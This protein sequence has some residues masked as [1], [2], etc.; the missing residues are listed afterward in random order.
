MLVIDK[1][2]RFEKQESLINIFLENE[3]LRTK[4]QKLLSKFNKW[5]AY[6]LSNLFI[7]PYIPKPKW[8]WIVNILS[9]LGIAAVGLVFVVNKIFI[10]LLLLFISNVMIH[11]WNKRNIMVYID[12]IP[13]LYLLCKTASKLVDLNITNQNNQLIINSI[14]S[15]NKLKNKLRLFK[16]ERKATSDIEALLLFYWEIIK[17]LF[18][19]EPLAVFDVLKKLDKKRKDIQI[20]FEYIGELDT[21]ISIATLRM[22][23]PYFCK[24]TL[25]NTTESF[26][27][28]DIYHPLIPDCVANSLN[29]THKSIM[30]IGSNMSGKTTFIRTVG[31]NLLLAQTINTC[32]AKDFRLSQTR[33]FSAIRISDDLL[34]DKS[35]YFEEVLTIKN[36]VDESLSPFNNVFLLDEIFRGT[37]TIERIAAGKAV[38]SYLA[39]PKNNIVF[40]S[41]HDIELFELLSDEYDLYHFT[42]VIKEEQICFDYKIKQGNLLTKNAIRILEL[43]AYPKEVIDEA[44]QISQLLQNYFH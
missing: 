19:I 18:L 31:I 13:Q 24:P 5:E 39:A 34:N 29:L 14:Q 3:E 38:L 17:I 12:S 11:L 26:E 33:L 6:Y 7:D 32:F 28:T 2:I 20:L 22:K 43:N 35:Y 40:V 15:I 36:M 1:N 23:V 9:I 37:N 10:L 30:L 4:V 25:S 44:R 41:T 16:I 27:F 42:E 21:A 8:F